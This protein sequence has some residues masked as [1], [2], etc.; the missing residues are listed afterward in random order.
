MPPEPV[1]ELS[2]A[3]LNLISDILHIYRRMFEE[4]AERD[5]PR[6]AEMQAACWSMLAMANSLNSYCPG[7]E[8]S[9]A[10]M[11]M[12]LEDYKIAAKKRQEREC[13]TNG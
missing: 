13:G 5:E 11:Q 8:K 4:C 7:R 3:E 2:C 9:F 10:A 1:Y 6:K 12:F